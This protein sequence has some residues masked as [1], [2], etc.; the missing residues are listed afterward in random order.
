MDLIYSV[1]K[2]QIFAAFA[3]FS[4]ARFENQRWTRARQRGLRGS[5]EAF[6]A[7]VDLTGMVAIIGAVGLLAWFG[8]KV[9]W[10]QAL[11][12]FCGTVVAGISYQLLTG[13]IYR[14]NIVVWMLGTLAIYPLLA[15]LGYMI[16]RL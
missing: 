9:G 15:L 10:L 14:D 13:F 3:A 7:F 4:I 8:F 2:T 11:I 5:S 1:V 12:V 6:G 16:W